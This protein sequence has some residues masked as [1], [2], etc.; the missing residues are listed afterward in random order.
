MLYYVGT[1]RRAVT[2]WRKS[3]SNVE[4]ALYV[5][6]SYWSH[7]P[8]HPQSLVTVNLALRDSFPFVRP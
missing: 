6:A 1:E 7:D 4:N 8:R 2:G 5:F 3:S